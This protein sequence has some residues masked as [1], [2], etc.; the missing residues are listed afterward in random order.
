[1]L[2]EECGLVFDNTVTSIKKRTM[3]WK[4]YGNA[5]KREIRRVRSAKNMHVR[6]LDN[7]VNLVLNVILSWIVTFPNNLV[8]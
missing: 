2:M 5:V 6:D 1:M 4:T 3:W 7:K 8:F